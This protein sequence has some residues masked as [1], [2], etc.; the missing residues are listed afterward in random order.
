MTYP[1]I[2][3]YTFRDLI[4]VREAASTSLVQAQY[5]KDAASATLD[6]IAAGKVKS[7][8]HMLVPVLQI[9]H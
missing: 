6:L 4:M 5:L 1:T 9:L 3:S 2:N 8:T 7:R